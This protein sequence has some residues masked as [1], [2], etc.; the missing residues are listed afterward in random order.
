ML[1]TKQD[2]INALES[3]IDTLRHDQKYAQNE[4]IKIVLGNVVLSL[5]EILEWGKK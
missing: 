2:L 5:E 1:Y 4:T 3:Y